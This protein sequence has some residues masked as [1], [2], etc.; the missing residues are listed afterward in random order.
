MKKYTL[1][2]L[3]VLLSVSVFS[4]TRYWVGG[5]SSSN[6][7]ATGNTNWSTTSGGA[8]NASVPTVSDDV[9]FDGVGASGN[10]AAICSATISFK[11]LTF[12]SGYTNTITLNAVLTIAGDFTDRPEHTWAGASGIAITANSTITSNGK[13]FPNAVTFSTSTTTKT[14]SGNWTIGGLFTTNGAH[15]NQVINGDTLILAG[16][17]SIDGSTTAGTATI[18]LTGTLYESFNNSALY[19]DILI[20]GDMTI[21]DIVIRG[22]K[23]LKYLS[24]NV[25]NTIKL[26]CTDTCTIDVAGISWNN[27][28]FDDK[29]T[30][31][32]LVTSNYVLFG[33]SAL[34]NILAGPYG[35]VTG[36]LWYTGSSG[37]I[38]QDNINTPTATYTINT[39]LRFPYMPSRFIQSSDPVYK[40]KLILGPNSNQDNLGSFTR[41]DA[42]VGK[43]IFTYK[44]IITDCINVVSLTQPPTISNSF[45]N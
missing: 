29:T 39:L 7:S 38:L 25:I 15:V 17:V 10:T 43:P 23:S 12:T 40:A 6:F 24:G 21:T 13:T 11:S 36:E 16:T 2:T 27:V 31:N 44:G 5:G 18:R 42:S 30:I 37:V 26:T 20:D 4:A 41:I 28:T 32:S 33:T 45:A 22:G 9:I 14:L 34:G 3:F 35:F 1:L 8:N 19:N